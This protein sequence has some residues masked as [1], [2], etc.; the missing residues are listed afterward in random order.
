MIS[1]FFAG[2]VVIFSSPCDPFVE[3]ITHLRTV[4]DTLAEVVVSLRTRLHKADFFKKAVGPAESIML[5]LQ[6]PVRLERAPSLVD[7]QEL[8]EY[9]A[10]QSDLLEG[11]MRSQLGS[12]HS[13][14]QGMVSPPQ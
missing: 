1:A 13:L 7:P 5:I 11:L 6:G 8:Q 10:A 4:T 3:K 9:Y 12:Q 2:S 14:P